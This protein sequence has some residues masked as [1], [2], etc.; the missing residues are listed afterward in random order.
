MGVI[1]DTDTITVLH[2]RYASFAKADL[3]DLVF[4]HCQIVCEIA[5]QCADHIDE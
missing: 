2:K 3:V 4:T 5:E 1:P